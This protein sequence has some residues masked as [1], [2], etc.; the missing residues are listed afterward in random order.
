MI[1]NPFAAIM[2]QK[3]A[4]STNVLGVGTI[5]IDPENVENEY[6]RRLAEQL[7]QRQREQEAQQFAAQRE[8]LLGAMQGTTAATEAARTQAFEAGQ[9]T[10]GA[11]RSGMGAGGIQTAALGGVGAGMAQQAGMAGAAEVAAAEQQRNALARAQM[12]ELLRQQEMGQ[13]GL[14]RADY[15]Q[16]LGA[17]RAMLPGA[18]QYAQEW[19]AAEADRQRRMEGATAQAIGTGIETAYQEFT[20]RKKKSSDDTGTIDVAEWRRG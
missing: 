15:A 10:A 12:A 9:A 7:G 1:P 16:I 18:Q 6:Q 14:E 19:A 5:R 8:R 4:P 2:P 11:A 3:R 20:G 13:L 17:Q